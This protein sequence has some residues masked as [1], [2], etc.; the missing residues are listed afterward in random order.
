M[1]EGCGVLFARRYRLD[2]DAVAGILVTSAQPQ[3]YLRFHDPPS[4]E[5]VEEGGRY[6][7]LQQFRQKDL[8][9]VRLEV[10]MDHM[11]LLMYAPVRVF[12]QVCT[13]IRA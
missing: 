5:K 13:A 6:R 8:R 1:T 4:F 7:L 10:L 12:P 9:D 2:E 11:L 3:G